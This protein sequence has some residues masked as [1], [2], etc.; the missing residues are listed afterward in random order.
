MCWNQT[1]SLNTFIFTLFGIN[2]AYLNNVITINDYIYY[3]S[4]SSIQLLEYFAWGNL[5]DKKMNRFLSQIGMF[6]IIMQPILFIK[7]L[8]KVESNIKTLVITLYTVFVLYC[9]LYFPIDFS[10]AKAPNGHLGWNWLNYPSLIIFIYI[11]FYFILL[12][13]TKSYVSFISSVM[14]FI[15][16]YYTYYKTNTWGSLWCWI[17]NI[18]TVYLIV[19]TFFNPKLPNCLLNTP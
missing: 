15:A 13:Y 6:L 7:S 16:I 10:M 8:D 3:L 14:L 5:N 19:K 18:V 11:F 9:I 12:L 1:I 2:F 17:A 4:F